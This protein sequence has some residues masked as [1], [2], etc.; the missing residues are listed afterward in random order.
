[1]Q[2]K[3]VTVTGIADTVTNG[4]AGAKK[5]QLPAWAPGGN[6]LNK[7]AIQVKGVGGSLTSW[8][9]TL[10]G[11]LDGVNWTTLAT[12]NANDGSTVFA[13]DKPCL[14]IRATVSALSL[15]TATSITVTIAADR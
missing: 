6:L 3:V 9:V 15:N 4:D 10:E 7:Y 5:L 14:A 11:S 12:H 1:M 13:V 2:A 8:T